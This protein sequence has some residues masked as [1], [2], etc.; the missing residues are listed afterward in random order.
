LTVLIFISDIELIRVNRD[1]SFE[2][3]SVRPVCL[4]FPQEYGIL[5]AWQKSLENDKTK[6]WVTGW[7]R[8]K[9]NQA[10]GSN[11]LQ[12]VQ[13]PL[14]SNSHCQHNYSKRIEI[15]EKQVCV[16]IEETCIHL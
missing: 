6:A 12:E 8:T 16:F 13:L 7:G 1:I 9:W 10:E 14:I 15:S 3:F 5:D 2:S 4:P 11:I